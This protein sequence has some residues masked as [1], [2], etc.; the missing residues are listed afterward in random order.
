MILTHGSLF[1]GFG[2]FNIGASWAG[3]PTLWDCEIESFNR[4]VLKKN[5]PNSEQYEDIRKLSHP[6]K[7]DIISGGFPCQD[8]SLNGKGEG[9]KG[10]RSGLW[11]EM[12]RIIREV[13]PEYVI[14]E[15]SS[16]LLIR[17][18]EQV[19]CDLSEIGYN[20]EW[21]CLQAQDFGY[22]HK[23][24]RLFCI[25]YPK[26][27]RLQTS[28]FKEHREISPLC[29]ESPIPHGV[30]RSTEWLDGTTNHRPISR[31]HGVSNHVD[32]I[33]GLGNA[34]VPLVTYY[35]FECIKKHYSDNLNE[36]SCET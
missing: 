8:I 28:I 24:E 4:S 19:L 9:I 12:A 34:V 25:A 18:F 21:D 13:R 11:S 32:I 26:T 14:I 3:I 15:N 1:S 23:R 30:Y 22:P 29:T 33:K 20:A 2:G 6:P 5:Y 36:Y 16:A 35:L 31:V 27:K 17:G 7:V 10:S